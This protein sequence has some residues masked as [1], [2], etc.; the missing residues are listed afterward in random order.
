M[1]TWFRQAGAA[2]IGLAALS[3]PEGLAARAVILDSVTVRVYDSAG[4]TAGDRSAAL[5]T[6]ASILARADLDVAWIVCTS[7]P[8]HRSESACDA[9]PAA[10]ELVVR[11]TN[12]TP[13]SEDGNR[14]AFGYSLLDATTGSG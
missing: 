14:R 9:P 12:S 8:D 5:R 6:A 10:H 4:V 13:A 11:L 1:T 2:L 7:P 3:M